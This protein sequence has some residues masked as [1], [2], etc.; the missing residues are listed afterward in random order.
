MVRHCRIGY[1]TFGTLDAAGGNAVLLLPWFMGR[2][3]ALARHIGP[4]RLVD[5]SRYYV[6]AVDGL[7]AGVSSSPSN[8]ATQPGSAFP[9]YTVRDMVDAE[10]RL[11]AHLGLR[12]LHAVVGTSL[13][14]MQVFE[15]LTAY[16]DAVDKGVAIAGSPRLLEAE[17]VRWREQAQSAAARPRWRRV[18]EAAARVAPLA[19]WRALGEN[20]I[21]C[22]YQAECIASTDVTAAHGGSLAKAAARVRARALVVISP[23]DQTVN[24]GPAAEF[25]HL[26][27]AS[28]LQLEG[29]GGH[30]APSHE[31]DRLWPAV[32]RFLAG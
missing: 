23:T 29:R 13:G 10:R 9:I 22:A 17:R 2:S 28:L 24:P 5:C 18:A 12:R 14:G 3:A 30:D 11:A 4:G 26:A 21:D 25:A 1:R 16:P 8:S 20:P 19:A 6:V 31:K 7:G 27:H 15:W 32:D